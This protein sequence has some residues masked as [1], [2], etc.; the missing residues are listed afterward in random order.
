MALKYHECNHATTSGGGGFIAYKHTHKCIIKVKTLEYFFNENLAKKHENRSAKLSLLFAE[1]EFF[2]SMTIDLPSIYIHTFI[3]YTYVQ[4][5][6]EI[7]NLFQKNLIKL[8]T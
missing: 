5:F 3:V 2:I 1:E 7:S 8:I 6:I 4:Y